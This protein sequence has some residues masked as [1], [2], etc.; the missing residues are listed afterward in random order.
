ME[1]TSHLDLVFALDIE[2]QIRESDDATRAE[3]LEA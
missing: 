1:H 2:N 3:V